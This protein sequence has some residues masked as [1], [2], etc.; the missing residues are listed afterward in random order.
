[1]VD[2]PLRVRNPHAEREVY[3]GFARA[4]LDGSN[5]EGEL[6][7]RA[8]FKKTGRGVTVVLGGVSDLHSISTETRSLMLPTSEP[9]PHPVGSRIPAALQGLRYGRMYQFFLL[10]WAQASGV[11]P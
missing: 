4:F 3:A 6:P 2:L 10:C 1:M 5:Q 11:V 7:I 9:C 8:W